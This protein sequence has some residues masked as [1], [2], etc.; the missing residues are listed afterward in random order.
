MEGYNLVCRKCNGRGYEKIS[1]DGN[2]VWCV[3]CDGKGVVD[4]ISNIVGKKIKNRSSNV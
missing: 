1:D 3:F 2:L 4:W